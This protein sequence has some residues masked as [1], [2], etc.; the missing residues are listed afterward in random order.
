MDVGGWMDWTRKG[1][2]MEGERQGDSKRRREGKLGRDI[3]QLSSADGPN[4]LKDRSGPEE[5]QGAV[6]LKRLRLG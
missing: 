1:D 3:G 4:G 5:K 2:S 6:W